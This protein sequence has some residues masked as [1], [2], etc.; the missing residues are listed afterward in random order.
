MDKATALKKK[1]L[2]SNASDAVK[3]KAIKKVM[4]NEIPWKNKDI[5]PIVIKAVQK[6]R[7]T[8]E[9]SLPKFKE[10]LKVVQHGGRISE[11]EVKEAMEYIK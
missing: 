6:A 1:I 8:D 10:M 3:A 5:A 2:L 7:D 11:S 4:E 9:K